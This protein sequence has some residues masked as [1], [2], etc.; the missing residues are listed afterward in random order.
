MGET[1]SPAA[2]LPRPIGDDAGLAGTGGHDGFGGFGR[3]F[4]T[5]SVGRGG[6]NRPEDVQT[7]SSFLSANGLLDAPV[8]DASEEFHRAVEAGQAKLNDLSNGGLLV[9]GRVKP[10]GPFRAGRTKDRRYAGDDTYRAGG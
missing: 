9:D 8:R 10:F 5:D 1:N 7:A 6:A 3:S 2:R 4:L